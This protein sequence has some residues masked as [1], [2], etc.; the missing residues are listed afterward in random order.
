M[1][2]KTKTFTNSG[3]WN[4]NFTLLMSATT[5]GCIGGIA[6][7]YALSFLVFFETGSVFASALILASRLIP[8]FILPLAIGPV[9]DRIP[10]KKMLIFGDVCNGL[11][12]LAMGT[13]MLFQPFSYLGYLAYSLLLSCASCVDELAFDS[14]L[15]MTITKGCEQKSYAASGMIYPMLNIIS[16]PAG[17]M[18]MAWIGVP[19]L[20]LAQGVLSL[21]AA[22]LE[23]QMR[24]EKDIAKNTE[25]FGYRAWLNDLKVAL[26]YLKNEPGL[27]SFYI[28]SAFS[29]GVANANA[30]VLIAFF[31]TAPGLSPILYSFFAAAECVGRFAGNAGQYL[32]SMR[33]EKK[34][35]FSLMVMIV[36]NIMDAILLF[37]SYPLMLLNR[38]ICGSLGSVSY[39]IRTA[40]IQSY[41]PEEIRGRINSFQNLLYYA[42]SSIL[43]LVVGW[44]ADV[45]S[46]QMVFVLG[47]AA[48]MAVLGLTW[49]KNRKSCQK[50]FLSAPEP[51]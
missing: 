15:P 40:A 32:T 16:M 33:N 38:A 13:W 2:N 25:D 21:A 31:S 7:N 9:L 4:R 47:A 29:N 44:I 42:V 35:G 23:A 3:V 14:I 43:I 36:Y 12:Y 30:P 24:L 11:L 50:I 20:L 39:T 5:C 17:A 37:L 22:F 27:L 49:V 46:A 19:V 10:R 45:L 8:S 28:Y 34:Y 41:I 1:K 26:R 18:V 48:G 51:E 6:A